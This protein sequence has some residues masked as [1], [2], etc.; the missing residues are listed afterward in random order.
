MYHIIGKFVSEDTE[1]RR[2]INPD[3]RFA[4]SRLRMW[5]ENC[6]MLYYGPEYSITI[7]CLK[8]MTSLE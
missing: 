5:L 3:Q 2:G 8:K 4:V 6:K 1:M 7:N